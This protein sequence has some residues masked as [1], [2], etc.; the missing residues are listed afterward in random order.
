MLK[1]RHDGSYPLD[2]IYNN[3][4]KP[5]GLD[6]NETFLRNDLLPTLLKTLGT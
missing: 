2:D 4:L 5:H 6:K 1:Y 3:F